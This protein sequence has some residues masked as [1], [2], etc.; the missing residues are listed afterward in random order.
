MRLAGI[1]DGFELGVRQQ[2]VG[3]EVRRQVRPIGR[4]RR[5]DRGHRRR[6][7]QL[8]RMRLRAGNTDRLQ[9]VFF[10]ERIR[11]ARALRRRPVDGL[12]GELDRLRFGERRI[13]GRRASRRRAPFAG[14]PARGIG[15]GEDAA[16]GK[17]G[18]TC[19]LDPGEQAWP[20]SGA[21]PGESGKTRR[22]VGGLL[23]DDDAAACRSW[24]RAW[25]RPRR[26]SRRRTRRGRAPAAGRRRRAR[27]E[28]RARSSHR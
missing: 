11:E 10:I 20:T 28:C 16:S 22:I 3:D 8:G 23:V 17:R 15:D 21:M 25:H 12:V 5:R 2:A 9:S 26:R 7:H 24:C 6:L 27:P 18:G 19:S 1:D 4:L 13:G 14:W